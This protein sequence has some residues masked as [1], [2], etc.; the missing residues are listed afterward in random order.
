[1]RIPAIRRV[2]RRMLGLEPQASALLSS[3]EMWPN[4]PARAV[5]RAKLLE[6]IAPQ[7]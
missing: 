6:A 3:L 4:D 7:S 5:A 1:M 2:V